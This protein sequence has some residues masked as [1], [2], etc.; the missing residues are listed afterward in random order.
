MPRGCA[1]RGAPRV[2]GPS[3]Y[4]GGVPSASAIADRRGAL[5]ARLRDWST[6][7]RGVLLY[8][9]GYHIDLEVYRLGVAT[10]LQGGDM[11]GP[12]PPTV[13]G[14]VLPFIYPPFA[15]MVLLPL[16]VLPWTAAWVA[17]YAASLCSVAVT[18]YL[19]ARRVWPE[20][21]RPGALS[22]ASA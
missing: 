13:S 1:D 21:G 18:L 4:R 5:R 20:G 22:V 6:E 3:G 10:W 7:P 15:A 19:V 14:L 11:Y 16:Q 2:A 17:L 12:L 8:T 9:H